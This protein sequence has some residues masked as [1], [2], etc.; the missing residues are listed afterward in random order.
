[1]E[2]MTEQVNEIQ[3]QVHFMDNSQPVYV[4][5]DIF[6]CRVAVPAAVTPP[7]GAS[8]APEA[9]PEAMPTDVEASASPT[10][11]GGTIPAT[12]GIT[13]AVSQDNARPSPGAAV[14]GVPHPLGDAEAAARN[15][16][17]VGE[18]SELEVEYLIEETLAVSFTLDRYTEVMEAVL[19]RLQDGI[20]SLGEAQA[21]V[22]AQ[23]AEVAMFF[24]ERPQ[25]V[26]EQE[27][28]ATIIKFLK[29]VSK[30]QTGLIKEREDAIAQAERKAR[31]KVAKGAKE[32]KSM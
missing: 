19:K 23:F 2:R 7:Q 15:A 17:P 14:A 8:A 22:N 21:A 11:A 10:T 28:W 27:W 29:L 9:P 30:V 6:R 3:Q 26:R 18:P 13:E 16:V 12:G 4:K 25:G 5:F 20:E 24:G 31:R 1:V 32:A